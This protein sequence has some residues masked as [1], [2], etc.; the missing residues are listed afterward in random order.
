MSSSSTLLTTS[1]CLRAI[2]LSSKCQ[3]VLK[4]HFLSLYQTLDFIN[5]RC[6]AK[7]KKI[8]GI[9]KMIVSCRPVFTILFAR[10]VPMK[11]FSVAFDDM[12]RKIMA[13]PSLKLHYIKTQ[14]L[15]LFLKERL[16][17]ASIGAVL[18]MLAGV[19]AA[20]QPWRTTPPQ[21]GYK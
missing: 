2:L 8:V 6:R 20:V 4:H 5:S 11:V 12:W 1:R 15:R 17:V 9:Q 10:P 13:L 19:L 16:S 21:D 3:S 14:P 18:L 7:A